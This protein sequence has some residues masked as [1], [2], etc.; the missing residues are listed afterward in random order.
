MKTVLSVLLWWAVPSWA[1]PGTILVIEREDAAGTSAAVAR[2]NFTTPWTIDR[3]A[4]M[5]F[6]K[7]AS[8]GYTPSADP[9]AV[10]GQGFLF[11]TVATPLQ[12]KSELFDLVPGKLLQGHR[13]WAD[14]AP[15]GLAPFA[16]GEFL[17]WDDARHALVLASEEGHDYVSQDDVLGTSEP[18]WD[19]N[20]ARIDAREV[21][22]LAYL[23]PKPPGRYP[24]TATLFHLRL[25]ADRRAVVLSKAPVPRREPYVPALLTA[26][27]AFYTAADRQ[28][29]SLAHVPIRGVEDRT[30]FLS[31]LSVPHGVPLVPLNQ[32]R[33]EPTSIYAQV[34]DALWE[35]NSSTGLN[36]PCDTKLLGT[37]SLDKMTQ[38]RTSR[39]TPKFRIVATST[40]LYP[41]QAT[42]YVTTFAAPLTPGTAAQLE[43]Q[44]S[45]EALVRM[46]FEDLWLGVRGKRPGDK[47][48]ASEIVFLL[49]QHVGASDWLCR[50][51]MK[52]SPTERQGLHL[53]K[54]GMDFYVFGADEDVVLSTLFAKLAGLADC[55][56]ILSAKP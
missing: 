12:R 19:V 34:G 50:L 24:V 8:F 10:G 49:N 4:V 37:A 18:I 54:G 15:L 35:I 22:L 9:K 32:G 28:S 30:S 39:G 17:A 41:H 56:A 29:V 33:R 52:L 47:L 27:G 53:D 5:P 7:G 55:V 44:K 31:Q 20:L 14:F 36:R 42:G 45:N 46:R 16:P 40:P 23:G 3:L 13:R 11:Q 48:A 43:A 2:T 38:L 1:G 6:P 26:V 21:L 25:E 51:L